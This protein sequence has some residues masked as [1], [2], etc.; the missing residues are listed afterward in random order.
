MHEGNLI[1]NWRM[2]N[3]SEQ[4]LAVCTGCL[5]GQSIGDRPGRAARSKLFL[6]RRARGQAGF[7]D[8]RRPLDI[9]RALA[10]WGASEFGPLRERRRV[11]RGRLAG[12][13]HAPGCN[14]RA[15]APQ[16]TPRISNVRLCANDGGG[17]KGTRMVV[18]HELPFEVSGI[19]VRP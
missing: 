12:L 19:A 5:R 17:P 1:V 13:L 18:G 9:G 6:P 4:R 15:H 2:F 16:A 11:P 3:G 10:S 14:L 7:S 8:E